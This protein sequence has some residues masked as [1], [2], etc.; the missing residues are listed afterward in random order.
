MKIN[1]KSKII[2]I[3]SGTDLIDTLLIK[4]PLKNTKFKPKLNI[5]HGSF[6]VNLII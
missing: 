2:V 5:N 6:T 3:Q 1:L 4:S